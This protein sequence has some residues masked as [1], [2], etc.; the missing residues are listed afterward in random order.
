MSDGG[1][2]DQ[3][4][5]DDWEE[6]LGAG[7][8]FDGWELDVIRNMEDPPAEAFETSWR[9]AQDILRDAGPESA[10]LLLTVTMDGEDL[11]S[12]VVLS[13]GYQSIPTSYIREILE[14]HLGAL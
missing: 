5:W 13:S 6:P 7:H 2:F 14:A 10:I 3:E 8:A 1:I 4:A 12:K 9:T 11:A